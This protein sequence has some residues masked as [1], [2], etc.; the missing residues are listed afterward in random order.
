MMGM[1]SADCAE[2]CAFDE[3]E[4]RRMITEMEKKEDIDPESPTPEK[5]LEKYYCKNPAPLVYK[6]WQGGQQ[7]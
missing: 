4:V 1:F 6:H 7:L 3:A 2:Y 5:S